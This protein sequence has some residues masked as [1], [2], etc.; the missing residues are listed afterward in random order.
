MS[1]TVFTH[2]RHKDRW[3]FPVLRVSPSAP[4]L[5][6][7]LREDKYTRLQQQLEEQV[8]EAETINS[9]E[10]YNFIHI[11]SSPVP[12][13][14]LSVREAQKHFGKRNS[15]T[16]YNCRYESKYSDYVSYYRGVSRFAN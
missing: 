8:Q 7:R 4:D 1:A 2:R 11:V 9:S 3:R 16:W 13:W 14:V 5:M 6:N 12:G 10:L 15:S